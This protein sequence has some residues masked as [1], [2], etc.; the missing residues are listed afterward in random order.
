MTRLASGT[1]STDSQS[2]Y[3]AF[4]PHALTAASFSSEGFS[5]ESEMQFI[6]KEHNLRLVEKRITAQYPD[7]PK[8]NV[9]AHGMFVLNG[10][11]RLVGQYRP[12]LFFGSVGIA[13]LILAFGLGYRV[14]L[15]FRLNG[16]LAAGTAML[17]ILF[18]ITGI[19]SL[20]TGII[21]HSM[22]SLLLEY[23]GKDGPK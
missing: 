22:R 4:S 16:Q 17:A 2:G 6:A 3:R 7:K 12:L 8:R 18:A 13:Q 20:S 9:L 21:L 10:F 11:L 15:L 23:I 5:V 1:T 19:L 14:V